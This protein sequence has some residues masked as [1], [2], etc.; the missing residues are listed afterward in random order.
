MRPR[1]GFLLLL[2]YM[3]TRLVSRI[4]VK[5]VGES[6]AAKI[7]CLLIDLTIYIRRYNIY[8]L[9]VP[10]ELSTSLGSSVANFRKKSCLES[11]QSANDLFEG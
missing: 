5:F 7:I 9:C 6:S 2:E 11:L 10:N 8:F 1:N 3:Q 4:K